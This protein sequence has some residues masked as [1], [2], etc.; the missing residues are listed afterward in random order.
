MKTPH[1]FAALL[2]LALTLGSCSRPA[3]PAESTPVN[4][5]AAI[6][7]DYRDVTV[8]PNIA[9]LNIRITAPGSEF[10]AALTGGGRSLVAGAGSDGKLSFDADEWRALLEASRG[11]SVHVQLYARREG[12]WVRFP[13]YAFAVAQEP[14]DRY[15]SY[16]LIEPGY[17][18]YRQLGIYQRDLSTFDEK[19]IYENNR[20]YDPD[21]NH[22]INC[23]N[24]QQHKASTFLF[25]VRAAHGGTVFVRDGKISKVDIKA[26]SILSGAVYPAWHPTQPWVVFSSNQTGQA[27]PIDGQQKTEVLDYGADLIFYDAAHNSVRN[28]FRTDTLFETF[29]CWT[30]DGGRVFYCCA[31]LPYVEGLTGGARIDTVLKHNRTIRNDLMSVPFDARTGRFGTPRT[32]FA[33]SARGKSV[34]LPRVSPDGRYVLFGMADFGQFHIWHESADLYVKDLR[35]D[36]VYAL[37]A[38]NAPGPDSYHAWSSNGRW[39]VFASRRDDANYSRLYIAYFGSDGRARK[40]FLLPQADPDDNLMRMKSYNVPELTVDAVT[41][42]PEQLREVVYGSQGAKATYKEQ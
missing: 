20:T 39:I 31:S 23:H 21:N 16:R 36:S 13:A 4:E 9:P 2:A 29:P 27:F 11:D 41:V 37:T 12:G 17:E 33:A 26:D 24:F 18:L 28:I 34:T 40:A 10:V 3:V 15:V 14:I 32:E 5:T 7:P 25:H 8:P 1:L 35:R 19:A 6:Y 38:A 22:C 42:T 30:P